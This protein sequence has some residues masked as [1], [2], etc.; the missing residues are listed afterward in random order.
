MPTPAA[1]RAVIASKAKADH[2]YG[3]CIIAGAPAW[4]GPTDNRTLAGVNREI[5][6]LKQ[7]K[8]FL[9]NMESPDLCK[10]LDANLADY[11]QAPTAA[12]A[13][14]L[15]ADLNRFIDLSRSDFAATSWINL[16]PVELTRQAEARVTELEQ[17]VDRL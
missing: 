16:V 4:H 14:E 13:D 10:D 1:V 9:E 8:A 7:E 5:A 17:L 3:L 2:A 12:K 6:R 15:R 11:L